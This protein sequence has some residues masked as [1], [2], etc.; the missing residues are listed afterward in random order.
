MRDAGPGRAG[1]GVR[2]VGGRGGGGN[3]ACGKGRGTGPR[4]APRAAETGG[5]RRNGPLALG[6]KGGILPVN[7]R[8]RWED[9]PTWVRRGPCEGR[10]LSV[11]VII[12][13]FF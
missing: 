1:S 3:D 8:L 9:P 13:L 2:R 11:L 12:L 5:P 6:L 7:L 4:A 10:S